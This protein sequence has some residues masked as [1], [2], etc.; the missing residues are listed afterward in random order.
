[1]NVNICIIGG[2][3][4]RDPELRYTPKGAAIANFGVATSRKF[5]GNDDSEKEET[6]FI[7]VTAWGKQA[8]L[9]GQYLK[10]GNPVFIE[11]RLKLEQWDDKATGSKRS[12]IGLVLEKLQFVGGKRDEAD[13]GSA[14]APRS[15]PKPPNAPNPEAG[16]DDSQIPF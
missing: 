4:T 5:R 15:Q 1:M 9:V 11:G 16:E 14:P 2:R 3:L 7:D 6:L 10:K 13:P 12:K 8:E